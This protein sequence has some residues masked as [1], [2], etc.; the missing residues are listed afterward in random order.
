VEG[1]D[2]EEVKGVGSNKGREWTMFPHWLHNIASQYGVA[3][4]CTHLPKPS[5]YHLHTQK[6][7]A[8]E[9]T[10]DAHVRNV[11][12]KIVSKQR[13][14]Q[15]SIVACVFAVIGLGVTMWHNDHKASVFAFPVVALRWIVGISIRATLT[16]VLR[17]LLPFRSKKQSKWSPQ[18][19]VKLALCM[20]PLFVL[21]AASQL[22][23]P[24][25][26][27]NPTQS[28]ATGLLFGTAMCL[29][30]IVGEG[31]SVYIRIV[32]VIVITSVILPT[33]ALGVTPWSSCAAFLA[34][35]AW[36]YVS[37]LGAV[38]SFLTKVV[39]FLCR[40]AAIL[41]FLT[42]CWRGLKW[43]VAKIGGLWRRLLRQEAAPD[44]PPAVA[45]PPLIA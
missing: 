16:C 43:L 28:Y 19:L 23:M 1:E 41:R 25:L 37:Q 26:W 4:P 21:A 6:A 32:A 36:F 30:V 20:A 40:P 10:W 34:A 39:A 5:L 29:R 14:Y 15:L 33:W 22:S 35:A 42:A 11:G 44:V 9:F 12:Q 2:W 24:V 7:H 13:V 31:V 3:K 38:V 17:H 8:T 45:E 27:L 18:P